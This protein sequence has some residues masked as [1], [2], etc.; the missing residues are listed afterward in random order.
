VRRARVTSIDALD[1]ERIRHGPASCNGDSGGAVFSLWEGDA[2]EELIAVVSSGPP[3]CRDY[4][5]ATRVD[6]YLDWIDAVIARRTEPG[7]GCA[8]GRASPQRPTLPALIALLAAALQR[9]IR[10]H[11]T[12]A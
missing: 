8:A 9:R 1:A 4:G 6:A 12:L 3:A 5:R 11:P 7:V 10:R 2:R